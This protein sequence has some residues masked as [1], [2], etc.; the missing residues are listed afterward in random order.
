MPR[1]ASLNT[2]VPE[3]ETDDVSQNDQ[4]QEDEIDTLLVC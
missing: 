2:E 4:K 1:K 3:Q